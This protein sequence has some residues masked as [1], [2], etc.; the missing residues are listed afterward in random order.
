[1]RGTRTGKEVEICVRN[2]AL[3]C[4]D[5]ISFT[6]LCLCFTEVL[7]DMQRINLL[8]FKAYTTKK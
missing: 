8:K 3:Y 7:D 1:M 2:L 6:S 5:A 4:H